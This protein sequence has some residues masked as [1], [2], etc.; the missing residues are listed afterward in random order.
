MV[1]VVVVGSS[2]GDGMQVGGYLKS[3]RLVRIV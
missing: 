2:I 1:V 3:R